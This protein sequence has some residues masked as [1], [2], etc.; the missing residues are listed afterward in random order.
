MDVRLRTDANY[1]R[2]CELIYA[3]QLLCTVPEDK[4]I[5]SGVIDDINAIVEEFKTSYNM[6]Q[7]HKDSDTEEPDT[8]KPDEGEEPTEG[9]EPGEEPNPDEQEPGGGE[10][11]GGEE[12]EPDD[13]PV[14]Q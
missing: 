8:E 12:P 7:G 14:V 11:G 4:E 9:T 2:I 3:S 1:N 6:S 13:R 5:I 10:E